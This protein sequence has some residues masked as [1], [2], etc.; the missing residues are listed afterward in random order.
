VG[1]LDAADLE[2][3]IGL[4]PLIEKRQGGNLGLPY[5]LMALNYGCVEARSIVAWADATLSKLDRMAS[6]S[7][8]RPKEKR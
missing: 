4:E 2:R 7:P 3:Y 1:V 5:Y 8:K 6:S